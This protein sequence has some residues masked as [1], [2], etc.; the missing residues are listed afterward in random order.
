[1]K[2]STQRNLLA[3]AALVAML[4]STTA[5]AQETVIAHETTSNKSNAFLHKDEKTQIGITAGWVA[6]EWATVLNGKTF[7]EDLWGNPNKLLQGVQFGINVQRCFFKGLG[8]RTGL[9]Y[10]WYIS[11]DKYIKELGFKRFN[12]HDLYIP[13]HAMFRMSPTQNL[14]IIPFGGI[15][16]NWA[17]FGK[18]KSGPWGV[19]DKYG[20]N[21]ITGRQYPIAFFD[22]NEHTP[23]HWNIQAEAGIAVHIKRTQLSFTYSW[24]INHHRLYD[25]APSRQN[26]LAANLSIFIYRQ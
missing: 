14:S 15:G 1:M 9:Y 23:H 5:T 6:K 3:A 20:F 10:E 18:L 25:V 7:H 11:C 4:L 13:L 8:I 24:G 21:K 17:M 19:T 26:K 22:Y 2:T 16:F 12:E